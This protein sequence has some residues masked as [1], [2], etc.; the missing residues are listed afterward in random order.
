MLVA[1]ADCYGS[2]SECAYLLEDKVDCYGVARAAEGARL[3]RIGVKKPILVLSHSSEQLPIEKKFCLIPSIGTANDL[4]TADNYGL[5]DAHIV[6]DTGMNRY[7]FK[8]DYAAADKTSGNDNGVF[9]N[10][11][12]THALITMKKLQISGLFSHIYHNSRLTTTMQALQFGNA[13]QY[14]SDLLGYTPLRHLWAS[15]GIDFV[16]DYKLPYYDM[17]RLGLSAYD[18]ANYIISN[19]LAVKH[20]IKGETIGYGAAYTA[21]RDMRI[22]IIEGG[23]ADGI[24]RNYNGVVIINGREAKVVG[25]VCMDVFMADV[26]DVECTTGARAVLLDSDKI[27]LEYWA[28]RTNKSEYEVLTGMRGRYKYVYLL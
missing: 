12:L 20:V 7:G 19:V 13:V 27:T 6:I 25:Y 18:N 28:A 14:I 5:H 24:P 3:R 26:T 9:V 1:K 16:N 22:A 15:G 2:G 17:V 4:I 8:S 10:H 23:Y 11:S 21:P